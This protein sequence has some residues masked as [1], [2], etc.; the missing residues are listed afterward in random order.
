MLPKR[1]EVFLFRVEPF[2]EGSWCAGRNWEGTKV[3][4]L[5]QMASNLPSVSSPVKIMTVVSVLFC[6][7]RSAALFVVLRFYVPVNS[8]GSFRERS[9]YLTTRL[10]GRLSPPS[11]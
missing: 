6:S 3:V 9:V 11:G 2:S 5:V 7:V 8:V 1:A 10:L 4:S